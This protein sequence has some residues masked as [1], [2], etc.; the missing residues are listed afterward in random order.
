MEIF[1][2]STLTWEQQRESAAL[3]YGTEEAEYEAEHPRPNLKSL[4]IGNRGMNSERR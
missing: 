3:G 2:L 4:L 1:T